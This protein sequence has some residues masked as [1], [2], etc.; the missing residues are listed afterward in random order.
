MSTAVAI[1]K[2][3]EAWRRKHERMEKK[4]WHVTVGETNGENNLCKH[5]TIDLRVP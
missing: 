1:L 4:L 2:I 3:T 5:K